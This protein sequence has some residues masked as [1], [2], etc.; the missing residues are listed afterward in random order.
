VSPSAF[1]RVCV[2][3]LAGAAV[4][5]FAVALVPRAGA[6]AAAAPEP[7]ADG[8]FEVSEAAREAGLRFAPD[9]PEADRRWIRAAVARAR[10][11]A[12]RLIAEVDGLVE[13]FAFTDG[14]SLSGGGHALGIT[15]AGPDGIR[16][17]FDLPVLDGGRRT[18]R[19]AVVLHELGHVLDFTIVADDVRARMDGQ[20]PTA[21]PCA[22]GDVTGSCAAPEERFADTFAKWALHGAVS[23]YGAG[24]AVP[25][26]ASLE[27][28]GAPLDDLGV[29]LATRQAAYSGAAK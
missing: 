22:T 20:I 3:I 8:T 9:V 24:Y 29:R 18:D 16:V 1:K 14:E 28:W 10:P 2:S 17:G 21:G 23:A 27:D 6:P 13:V 12:R 7:R 25:T 19:D 4:L 11:N 26:P 5:A 15:Q